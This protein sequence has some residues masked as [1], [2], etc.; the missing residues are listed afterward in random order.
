MHVGSRFFSSGIL[1]IIVGVSLLLASAAGKVAR[2]APGTSADSSGLYS[3][4]HASS[5]SAGASS[6][7]STGT[8]AAGQGI[9]RETLSNGLRVVIVPDN[10]APVATTMVNYLVGS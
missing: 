9:L 7:V 5:A 10:L 2:Q 4:V 3:A 1:V 6:G 8:A